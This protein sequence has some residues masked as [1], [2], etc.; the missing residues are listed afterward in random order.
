MGR[1]TILLGYIIACFKKAAE[2]RHIPAP[3]IESIKSILPLLPDEL[4]GSFYQQYDRLNAPLLFPGVKEVLEQ[5][6]QHGFLMGIA[7]TRSTVGMVSDL[8]RS[9]LSDYFLTIRCGDEALP[10]PHPQMLL[11]IMQELQVQPSETLMI[12]DMEKICY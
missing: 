2:D 10:K 5:L 12:G 7:T 8:H 3:S 9:K 1:Y 4:M 6:L 11:E